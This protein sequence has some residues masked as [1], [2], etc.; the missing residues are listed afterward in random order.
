[1]YEYMLNVSSRGS[2]W[3]QLHGKVEP[4]WCAALPCPMVDVLNITAMLV[5]LFLVYLNIWSAF[6]LGRNGVIY[7]GL[8][9]FKRPPSSA[10]PP[11]KWTRYIYPSYPSNCT[12]QCRIQLHNLWRQQ[13]PFML[14][15]WWISRI[16]SRPNGA[17]WL[18]SCQQQEKFLKNEKKLV[19]NFPN[20]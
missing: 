12:T 9:I 14:Y 4:Q 8:S 17:R 18:S 15:L 11:W 3:L 1:M 2:G 16:I 19:G 6:H 7:V 10:H 13:L 5:L 20:F